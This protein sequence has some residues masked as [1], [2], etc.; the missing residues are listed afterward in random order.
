MFECKPFQVDFARADYSNMVI[1]KED[2][3]VLRELAK[4]V[5]EVA[6]LP[7]MD[8]KK[9]LWTAHNRLQ[10]KRPMVLCDPEH[11]WNEILPEEILKCKGSIARH[12]E[13]YLRKQL[14]WGLEMG[15]DYI[16]TN[17]MKIPYQ[18][19]LSP[20]RLRSNR[21]HFNQFAAEFN[22]G[23][24]GIDEILPDFDLLEEL[25]APELTVDFDLSKKTFALA[26]E[27]FDG[28]L[29]VTPYTY[30]FW[31]DGLANAYVQIRGL[32]NMMTDFYDY[33]DEMAQ[34]LE[35]IGNNITGRVEYLEK[36]GLLNQNNR[37]D[38]AGSGGI[39]WTDEIPE[40]EPGTVTRKDMWGLGEAQMTSSV[41][42]E[43]W[44]EFFF[45]FQ[46]KYL[47][48]FGLVCFGCCEPM[49]RKFQYIKELPN[50]RRVSASHWANKESL[51]EQLGKDY[52]M[53]I[54]PTPAD[55]A[56]EQL[57]QEYARKNIRHFLDITK[58]NN[59]EF[60]MKDN[61]TLCNNPDNIKNWTRIVKEEIGG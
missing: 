52:I 30:W 22:G 44:K 40:V 54:K 1:S 49:E 8:E 35:I 13:F 5:A 56:V 47:E 41:S 3:A 50:L 34:L 53:S 32:E 59:V 61:H 25:E 26:E 23:A 24:Y 21:S 18:Y 27:V 19:S 45:P 10:Q 55:L 4:Q 60:I 29:Q 33:P 9:K 42:P 58:N 38:Y 6:A 46:K 43:M 16:V 7:V 17:R 57:D 2:T 20:W 11:G 12:W 37:D 39:G 36:S 15:D 31:S 48:K 28:I 51:S 14:F